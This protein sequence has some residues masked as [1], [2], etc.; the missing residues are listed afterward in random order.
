MSIIVENSRD[1]SFFTIFPFQFIASNFHASWCL[2]VTGYTISFWN[3]SKVGFFYILTDNISLSILATSRKVADL[4]PNEIILVFF[5]WP[6][7]PAALWPLGFSRLLTE[8]S[9]G[10]LCCQLQASCLDNVGASMSNNP[11]GFHGLL[12]GCSFTIIQYSYYIHSFYIVQSL[13]WLTLLTDFYFFSKYAILNPTF[14]LSI[15][16][17]RIMFAPCFCSCQCYRRSST[18]HQPHIDFMKHKPSSA[19]F[20]NYGGPG[21]NNSLILYAPLSPSKTS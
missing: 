8:M 16:M 4:I 18:D 10:N 5:N 1:P 14:P 2:P 20:V 6:N 15:S 12:R 9:T 13:Q 17:K 21:Q 7:L 11:M 3:I 19:E